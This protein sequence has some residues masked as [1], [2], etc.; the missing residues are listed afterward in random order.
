M[1]QEFYMDT[2]NDGH[3]F[4][5]PKDRES[6]WQDFL[7]LDPDDEEAWEPPIW[8]TQVGGSHTLVSFTSFR[9]D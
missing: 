9:I 3:W 7:E 2:D 4:V 8:T 1:T 5:I 6:E